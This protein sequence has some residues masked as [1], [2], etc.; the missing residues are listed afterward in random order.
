MSLR[1]VFFSVTALSALSQSVLAE[2]VSR[3][4]DATALQRVEVSAEDSAD[5]TEPTPS[6]STLETAPS[7][8]QL[9]AQ[10]IR[11]VAGTQGDPLGAINT[12]PGVV[13]A[14]GGQGRAS[15]FFVRGSNANE[16][17][18]WVDGLP[19]GYIYHAGGLYSVLNPD[20]VDSFDTYLGGF[21]VEYGDRLGGVVSVKTRAPYS[22]RLRQSYQIGLYDASARIEGPISENSSGFFAVRRSYVDLL[23]PATGSLG[24]SD[25][26]YVQFP[27]YWD[28]QARYRYELK[29][30]FFDVSLFTADDQLKFD[31]QDERN[32]KPD[33]A[34]SGDLGSKKEFQTLGARW[35]S[36]L[37]P[38]LDQRIRFG[39][40][41]QK[42]D[43]IIGTQQSSDPNPGESFGIES[44][45]LNYFV[46]PQWDWQAS[47]QQNWKFGLDVYR[48]QYD[49]NGYVP[50]PCREGEPDC[51]ITTRPKA[52]VNQT[53]T[54]WETTPYVEWNQALRPDL[55]MK[56]GVRDTHISVGETKLSGVSPRLTLEYDLN[57]RTILNA[58]WGKYIQAPQ[59]AELVD[60]LGNPNLVMTESEHRIVGV[61]YQLSDAWSAQV[62]A[63]HKPMKKL[64]V[65]RDPP[66][67]YA[68]EGKGFAQGFDVLLK[69]QWND[70]TFG[71][72][73]YSY[74]ETER[75]DE[76]DVSKRL[77]DGDQP[78]TINV[79]WNQ[80]L[81]GSWSNWVWGATVKANSG[82]PY[83]QIVGREAL[84]VP[85]SGQSGSQCQS[86]PNSANC[87]WQAKYGK[88]NGDRLPFYV[89]LDLSLE[90]QWNYSD[91]NLV[92]R[93]ELLNATG[94]LRQNVVGYKYDADYA[95]YDNPDEVTD[96]PFL[97]SFSV[98]ANF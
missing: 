79:V 84:P 42:N 41:R 6:V 30:G 94:L 60:E 70:D 48:I 32:T 14:T 83:T 2:T 44:K 88:T 66:E 5:S 12:L 98:R 27:E 74:L 21:G 35:H 92:T 67:N 39:A 56:L 22:D 86:N 65:Q 73:G 78:H 43:F 50:R 87:Y 53:E 25:N 4:T 8:I 55:Y 38:E 76:A 24:D 40:Y 45:S 34:L 28:M 15:G 91:W 93:F 7:E 63:Y 1:Y 17:R 52:Q 85:G 89:R 59:G 77:F 10:E 36:R 72:I 71:W 51:K 97:P 33:P 96:F 75:Q 26:K 3:E 18:I 37:T 58:T 20:F 49:V 80:R 64:V 54:G 16:N 13:T 81:G 69:R 46:L 82:Q 90:R 19:L 62:E 29:D 95:N 11:G 31:I 57:D 47:A 9:N 23:L 61:K 68:N